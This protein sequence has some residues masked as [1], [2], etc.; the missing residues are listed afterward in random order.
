M[1]KRLLFLTTACLIAL[2]VVLMAGPSF[3]QTSNGILAGSIT[4]ATG[5]VISGATVTA[6]SSSLGVTR[7]VSTGPTG[8]YRIEA[9]NPGVYTLTVSKQGFATLAIDQIVVQA[10]II[11]PVDGKLAVGTST[12]EVTV[13][14]TGSEVN[15]SS[16]ELSHNISTVEI[17]ALPFAS[18]NPIQ[19]VLTQPGVTDG[20]G[21]TASNGQAFS[22]NGQ[23]ARSNNFLIDGQDNNDNSIQGQAFQPINAAAISEVTVM[24]NS[25]AAEFGRGGSSVTN[26]IYKSGTNQYHGSVWDLYQGSG[27]EA[28]TAQQGLA[29]MTSREKPRYDQHTFGFAAGGPIIKNKLFVFGSSQWQKFYGNATPNTIHV[30]TA[31]GA[32]LLQSLNTPNANLLLQYYGSLRAPAANQSIDLGGGRGSVGFGDF[33]RPVTA[34]Q[35]PD[36]QWN[37]KVDYLARQND[38]F[39]FRYFHDRGSL[40][41]DFFNFPQSLPGFDTL[42]GGPSENFGLSWTHTFNQNAVNEFR[43]S[44][45]HFDFQFLAT[46]EALANPLYLT[47]RITIAGISKAP[48]FGVS[49]ALP[50]GRGHQTYQFQDGM[51][52]VHGRHV[53]KFGFDIARLLVVDH[54]PFNFFGAETFNDGGGFTSLGNFVDN[55]SGLGVAATKT[56]GS[57][58]AKPTAMQQAFYLQDAW[59]VKSNLTFTWGIRYE[60]QPNPENYLPYP[61][62]DT[63][64]GPFTDMTRPVKVKEDTNNWGPRLGL[65]YTPH[66]A[67]GLFG[68]NKTVLRLGYGIFY[69]SFYT[70][71][72]DNTQG[73]APNSVA[74]SVS[75]T[76]GRGLANAYQQVGLMT[77]VLNPATATQT[78]MSRY[79]V[80]PQ[81][82]QWNFDIQRELPGAMTM[83]L[84][85]VGVRGMHLF[86]SDYFNPRQGWDPAGLAA[87]LLVSTPR[88]NP[89]RGLITVR[90]SSGDSIYHALNAKLERRFTKGLFLRAAYTWAKTIDD[91]SD[92]FNLGDLGAVQPQN[93]L[94]RHLERGL[95]A[96]NIGQRFVITY[97]YQVPGLKATS[98]GFANALTYITRHWEVSGTTS[99]QSGVPGTLFA[100]GLDLVGTGY[101]SSARPSLGNASA[102]INTVGID[103]IFKAGQTAGVLYS[104]D[105]GAVVTA[106]DVHWIVRPAAGNVG[107]N[108]YINPGMWNFN[109]AFTRRF[110]MPFS[111]HQ[112]LSFR[113]DFYNLFNHP[114]EDNGVD[115]NVRAGAGSFANTFE[116]REGGRAIRMKIEYRF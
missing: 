71:M 114:N 79:I 52:I 32:A 98:N 84:A 88:I 85:Y 31:A 58:L 66:F 113:A 116:A 18:L 51:S 19:L 111:E 28:V 110:I 11:T 60:F 104:T 56:F 115:T 17:T 76:T 70:N 105:T 87:G 33:Q 91:G 2:L 27:L 44:W 53:F 15:T 25:Y 48:L 30:P 96:Q 49:T 45:G 109:T 82:H 14:A 81:T 54:I 108:S 89:G 20:G 112:E 99:A 61:G 36:L 102:P 12:V 3:A 97:V 16:A 5:A 107:R 34:Q 21:R 50:Q 57:P 6:S 24:T 13:H 1:Q 38:A 65:A 47:P 46:P 90:Q 103:G 67:K 40:V 93:P 55:F 23:S 83:T 9:I 43:A 4:D 78:S 86:E 69:D 22:V 106:N 94:N 62:Y 80:N 92:P 101:A 75:G 7:T 41:P 42:Q 63:S 100:S 37:V 64:L 29:G 26:V 68:D 72:L 10:S 35:S 59:K 74:Q 77:A 73:A 39:A 8:A 95:A